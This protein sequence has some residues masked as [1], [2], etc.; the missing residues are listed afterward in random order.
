MVMS[1]GLGHAVGISTLGFTYL[2]GAAAL[3][4]G[5]GSSADENTGFP[6]TDT[7]GA[8][9]TEVL[10]W[11]EAYQAAHSGNGGKDWDINAKSDAELTADAEARQLIGVCGEDQRPVIPLIAWEYGGS[12]HQWINP[13]ASAL[14]YCVYIPVVPSTDNWS[15]EA[16]N[17]HVIS[18][19]YVKFA[20]ENPC[21]A[22]VGAN[23]VTSC[24]GAPSNFEI[25]VDTASRHDGADVGLSLAEASSELRLILTD[26]TKVHLI[27]NL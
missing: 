7:S 1:S 6:W 2:V 3:A 20:A 26:G 22:E 21:A 18:D 25:L 19:V 24:I 16:S 14:C 11:V 5:C 4:A 12:D 8:S 10:M 9:A 17:D 15:Y 23:Q 13:A 27:D